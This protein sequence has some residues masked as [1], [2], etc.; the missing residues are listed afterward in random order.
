MNKFFKIAA[1]SLG[2]TL[3]V[4][5]AAFCGCSAQTDYTDYIS[6]KRSEIYLY[7]D[8]EAQIQINCV[9]REQPYAADGICADMCDLVEIFVKFA[10]NPAEAEISVGDYSGELNYEAVHTRFTATYSSPAFNAQGVDVTVKADGEEKNYRVLNVKDSGVI[11]C[12]QAVICASEYDRELFESLCDKGR[13]KGEIYVRLLY[14][15][16]CYY[17]VG[18]CGRD[19]KL[20]AYLLDGGRGKVISTKKLD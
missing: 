17:Y 8:D 1:L 16:G 13:F 14:D 10:K 7:R 11:S 2:V 12:E 4:G 20:T 19:K 3:S 18:V 5:A 6:E 9:S 15:E